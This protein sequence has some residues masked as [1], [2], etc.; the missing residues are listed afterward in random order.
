[1]C[2]FAYSALSGE[3]GLAR[4][5]ELQKKERELELELSNILAEKNEIRLRIGRLRPETLDLDYIE[6]IA[7]ERLAYA[8]E[9]EIILKLPTE[10]L[11]N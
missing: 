5:T 6:E 2:Y 10:T 4:W 11:Q 8:R 1:L 3:Q 7:R 9:D